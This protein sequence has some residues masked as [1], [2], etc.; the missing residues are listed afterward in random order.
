MQQL[1]TCVQYYVMCNTPLCQSSAS[2]A[3]CPHVTKHTTCATKAF[4]SKVDSDTV[5]PCMQPCNLYVCAAAAIQQE[6]QMAVIMN[7][8]ALKLCCKEADEQACPVAARP[9]TQTVAGTRPVV[10]PLAATSGLACAFP[11][12][13][14]TRACLGI[15][16][17]VSVCCLLECHP[18]LS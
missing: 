11:S 18:S 4:R 2:L 6:M 9:R 16:A 13:M 7:I 12:A 1:L 3:R 17:G 10:S 8:A 15:C 14:L 5:H